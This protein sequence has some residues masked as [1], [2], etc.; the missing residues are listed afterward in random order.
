MSEEL[1]RL[2]TPWT[3]ARVGVFHPDGRFEELT[4]AEVE[5]HPLGGAARCVGGTHDA[6]LVRCV[7]LTA[8]REAEELRAWQRE[9]IEW[10]RGELDRSRATEG[11]L[12]ALLARVKP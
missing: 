2:V 4:D 10:F 9:A 6:Q 3:R 1:D 8:A 12:R 11:F 7:L 5:T